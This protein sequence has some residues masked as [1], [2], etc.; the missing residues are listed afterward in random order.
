MIRNK[1]HN[2]LKMQLVGIMKAAQ[3]LRTWMDQCKEYERKNKRKSSKDMKKAQ[4]D[5]E[6]MAE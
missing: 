2:F 6:V 5:Y 3:S 1:F 4:T